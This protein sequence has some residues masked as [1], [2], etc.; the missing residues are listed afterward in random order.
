MNRTKTSDKTSPKRRIAARFRNIN[1]ILLL[2]I[3][4][5][6]ITVALV[7]I[8]AIT[9][10]ASQNYVRFYSVET[11][12]KFGSYLNRELALVNKVAQSSAVT[13]W[14]AD[15]DNEDKRKRAYEEMMDYAGMLQSANLYF[16]I[17]GSLNEY[18][19][20]E[21]A[22]L[23]K[24]VPF[25][26]IDPAVAYNEWYFSCTESDSEYTLN[27]DVDKVTNT[28]RLW[29]NHKVIQN[30][31]VLGVFCSGLNFETVG[32]EVF[33]DYDNQNVHGYIIDQTGAIQMDSVQIAKGELPEENEEKPSVFETN[34]ADGFRTAIQAYLKN[35]DGHFS[36]D[37]TPEIIRLQSGHYGYMSIAPI[38]G[39]SWSV[40]ALYNSNSLFSMER[41]LLMLLVMLAAFAVYTI[42]NDL[43][44]RRI[45]LDPLRKLNDSIVNA[46]AEGTIY[47]SDR[48]DEFSELAETIQNMRDQ[49]NEAD[50]RVRVMLDATP[51]CCNFWDAQF[52]NIDCNEEAV[53][54]FEL[55]DKQEY[56]DR[57]FELSPEFQPDGQ[58][59]EE[60]A[61]V[62]IKEAYANGR[63]VFEWLHQKLDGTPIPAE[64]TLVR[65]KH[66]DE[67]IVLGY[68]RDLRE[69]KKMIA[70]MR[71]ADE[72]TRL[73]LD[74]TPLCCNLWD[75]D[76]NNIDCNQEAV[77]L[78]ELRDKQEYL[79]RFFE[80]SPEIQPD[81]QRTDEK[82]AGMIHEAFTNG[83]VVFEWMHQKLDGTPVPSEITL[84]RVKRG[85]EYIVAGY[86]RDL[87]EYKKMIGEIEHQDELLHV[88][89][90]AATIL[91]Q[92]EV[93]EFEKDLWHCMGMMA[94]SVG[95]DRVYIW[96]NHVSDGILYGSQLYEWSEG[97]EPQQGNEYTVNIPYSENVPGW[98]EKLSSGQC[99]N[100]PVR[101]L[102]KAEQEQLVPQG[103]LSILV[104]PVF[105]RDEFW[106]F[107]G[108][109]D[110]HSERAFT[111]NEESILRSGSLLIANAMLRNEMTLSIRSSAA[112]M[113]AVIKN[114]AG[115]I[116]CIDK[117]Y[118][119]TL[120]NGLYLKE[121]GI[122]HDFL[123]GKDLRVARKK[124][125][126]L[127]IIE[128]VEKTFAEG[129]QDWIANVDGKMFRSHTTPM[130]DENGN[131]VGVV[132]STDD[133]TDTILLQ[134]ELE[135]AVE[136]AQSASQAK[137]NFLSNM[138]HEMRT[139]MNAIIG[140]TSI[141]KSAADAT[142]KDYA[143]GKIEEASNHLLGVI[144][145][146]LDMSKIEANRFELSSVEF[147]FE[148]MLQ[149]VV[150]VS[151][152][153]V[154]EKK[155]RFT[156]IIDKE[157]PPNLVGDDQR[158]AQVVTNLL[159]NAVKFT[160][161]EGAIK[162]D[163]RLIEERDGIC[164]IR[165]SL[166]DSGIGISEEQQARLFSSFVQAENSTSRKFGGTG[167]GLAI[168]KHIV[169]EMGGRI[170]IESE[171]GRGSSFK[172][173]VDL[174]RAEQ[175]AQSLLHPGVNRG[176]LRLLAVD[177]EAETREYFMNIADRLGIHCDTAASGEEA[178]ERIRTKGSYDLY[179]VDWK[180]P[181]MD[182]IEL[183]A[184]IKELCAERS[185]IIMI[186]AAQWNEIET[187]ALAAG[188][189]K[190]LS[191]PL[192][193]SAV[194]DCINDCIGEENAVET[195]ETPGE[196]EDCFKGN[197]ILL[198]E[199]V[200]INR[201]IVLALLEP[202]QLAIDCAVNG[203]EA[204]RM[205]E[206]APER[207]DMI[208]MDVQMPEMDG[209][210]ATRRIRALPVAKAKDIPIVAMT[211]NVFREDIEKCLECGM[212]DHVGKPL[213]FDGVL[214][215]LRKYL[216]K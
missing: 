109:D 154:D 213:D 62:M 200:E 69:Y 59:S 157:I 153:R 21:G 177:D 159:S 140:M 98:E 175:P 42:A 51:L 126:H 97:A 148:K 142:R 65:V 169:E 150:N 68:T 3:L 110:C 198:A 102:S 7:M 103:I 64:I 170:W 180:M 136:A 20:D 96:K 147:N 115:V 205:F 163:T 197:R 174:K 16:G 143:F 119:I 6:V 108:F 155:Q 185:V 196:E 208:F 38:G 79:D 43:L 138:S 93:D 17:Q 91:L 18:S 83:R 183:S 168:S 27:I 29:I 194:A 30:G 44:I 127:D 48:N 49:M 36:P 125:R 141:G 192:F 164:T 129:P 9:Q 158:L 118:V 53:K 137:S 151:S 184:K 139:P 122:R 8:S 95:V 212:N 209:M 172:F 211:A 171:I 214:D 204:V 12:E 33:G 113:E 124:N 216:P 52:N 162:L 145:D 121:L 188:V 11:V 94:E 206:E 82:A 181:G 190:F 201:E 100:G 131:A 60:K 72:R 75:K 46:G 81:G 134:Q 77:K 144:N 35:V 105:L 47:G 120:F 207:Y 176:N 199:D 161:E 67:D 50:A 132:G 26:I 22:S 187:Q 116:W 202:T 40:V 106:G 123:E 88:V 186:S 146:I 66:G 28:R 215:K 57:F 13:N 92:S 84:V 166:T 5:V 10:D 130:Y 160:P 19:V 31:K 210:E 55:R 203:A 58:R 173:T 133:I 37:T 128:N 76:L 182:G 107:V 45:A 87:R 165:V 54:L 112:Q 14:F 74:A 1:M 104:I 167:L 32:S 41:L 78:F 25:D 111:A 178:I 80:L 63:V 135:K 15:E 117:D 193:P 99:V 114:Y 4:A 86:T 39:T 23:E 189:D 179:F 101:N 152:F 149:K 73:M 89:N 70:E 61:L 191:K 156:V 90:D 56:L 34:S 195:Q 85:E 2:A 24:F 71:D